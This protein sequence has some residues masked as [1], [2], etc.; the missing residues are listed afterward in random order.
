M[1]EIIGKHSMVRPHGHLMYEGD[2]PSWIVDTVMCAHCGAHGVYKAGCG[3]TLGRCPKC[4]GFV[5]DKAACR[6]ECLPIDERL[7]LYEE[8]KIASL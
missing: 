5:C 7:H 1:P 8:G 4:L 3:N 2:D 6:A